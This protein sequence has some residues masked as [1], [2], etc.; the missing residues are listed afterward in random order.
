MSL[1]PRT[2]A[3]Y[4]VRPAVP[5]YHR[6]FSVDKISIGRKLVSR[7]RVLVPPHFWVRLHDIAGSAGRSWITGASAMLKPRFG[8]VS[9]Q[10]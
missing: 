2:A 1:P 7:R 5:S 6:T 10:I 4:L 3:I 9:R 8:R